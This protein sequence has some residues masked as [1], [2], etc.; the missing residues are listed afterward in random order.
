MQLFK[1]EFKLQP[2]A[3]FFLFITSFVVLL[4]T[5][6]YQW[7]QEGYQI[8]KSAPIT[9]KYQLRSI[10]D[11]VDYY[12]KSVVDEL[13]QEIVTSQHSATAN[14]PTQK[15]WRLLLRKLIKTYQSRDYRQVNT[16]IDEAASRK[17]NYTEGNLMTLLVITRFISRYYQLH[18]TKMTESH[19]N[20]TPRIALFTDLLPY[21]A[22]Y[23][24]GNSHFYLVGEES[25]IWVIL[26]VVL[27]TTLI[28][29]NV[30]TREKR[31]QT[32]TFEEVLPVNQ[33]WIFA[34]RILLTW[35][36]V[37]LFLLLSLFISIELLHL[38]TGLPIGQLNDGRVVVINSQP[39]FLTYL[40]HLL[41]IFFYLNLWF[42]YLISLAILIGNFT[43]SWLVT[44][45]LLM[46][47]FFAGQ[48]GLLSL[49]PQTLRQILPA[50]YTDFNAMLFRSGVYGALTNQH[51]IKVFGGWF[52]VIVL[53]L[54][55]SKTSK[56][57]KY[58]P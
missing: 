46:L 31:H 15:N 42:V 2:W 22:A 47:N 56:R 34:I 24:T 3:L 33:E 36:L 40:Q 38:L 9:T 27:F 26:L 13:Q 18:L 52:I 49:L 10:P 11:E 39:Q 28:A 57:H 25:H 50:N 8:E 48:L 37:N 45:F 51:L 35:L 32:E 7:I 21:I 4:T 14:Q 30:A 53:L 6:S 17:D 19:V 44:S 29:A 23:F 12:T 16:L 43:K 20:A 55:M 58:Y 5:L 41:K 1:K 54:I